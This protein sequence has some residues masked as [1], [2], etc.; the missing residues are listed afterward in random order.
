MKVAITLLMKRIYF[1]YIY[2]SWYT[3][4]LLLIVFVIDVLFFDNEYALT[5]F[6]PFKKIGCKS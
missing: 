3:I 6:S 5:Y 1:Y 2:I 4:I